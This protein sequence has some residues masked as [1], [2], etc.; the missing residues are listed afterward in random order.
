MKYLLL[1]LFFSFCS[2]LSAQEDPSL[3]DLKEKM[4]K[5]SKHMEESEKK[6]AEASAPPIH[7]DV[8]QELLSRLRKDIEA[9]K[10]D[11]IREYIKKHPEIFGEKPTDAQI[12]DILKNQEVLDKTI[13]DAI[14]RLQDLNNAIKK[15]AEEADS[16][17]EEIEASIELVYKLRNQSDKNDSQNPKNGENK[18]KTE[19][20][21]DKEATQGNNKQQPESTKPSPSDNIDQAQQ[22]DKL[23]RNGFK[24]DGKAKDTAAGNSNEEHNEP[25]KYRGFW[26]VWAKKMQER[27]K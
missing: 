20:G 22:S 6:L 21:K 2:C 24:A 5:A 19:S 23:D 15:Q 9:G 25:A 12:A 10:Y 18:P 4:D 14:E 27:T 7:P 16:A 8:K 3:K 17:A 13:L 26:K 11:D 1:I